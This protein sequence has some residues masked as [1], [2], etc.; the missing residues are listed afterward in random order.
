[1]MSDVSFVPNNVSCLEHAVYCYEPLRKRLEK[2]L[3]RRS[4]ARLLRSSWTLYASFR[5]RCTSALLKGYYRSEHFVRQCYERD[6]VHVDELRDYCQHLWQRCDHNG[7]Q[8]LLLARERDDERTPKPFCAVYLHATNA[9]SVKWYAQ[10]VRQPCTE[11]LDT[12]YRPQLDSA[13]QRT[14]SIGEIVTQ[15]RRLHVLNDQNWISSFQCTDLL[16]Y[17]RKNRL[18]RFATRKHREMLARH[19][20]HL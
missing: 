14:I 6:D 11:Q 5:P 7:A 18:D 20:A 3:E 16:L 19:A 17:A 9:A 10:G 15:L 4:F 2:W 12:S 13:T 8:F 1:M